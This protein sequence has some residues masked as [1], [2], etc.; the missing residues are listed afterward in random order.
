MSVRGRSHRLTINYRT[1]QEI[2]TWAVR[3]LANEKP[4]GLD[5]EADTLVGYRSTMHGRR[6]TIQSNP[7]REAEHE[8]LAAQIRTRIGD[9]VEPSSIGVAARHVWAAKSVREALDAAQI[10][11]STTNATKSNAVRVGTVHA[12]KGLEFRCVAVV[13]VEDGVVPAKGAVTTLAED[14]IAHDHDHQRERCLAFVAGTRA[15]D[16]LY[17]SYVGTPSPFLQDSGKTG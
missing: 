16:S 6:P 5:D 10:P 8:R 9:G 11:A 12:M 2:L 7:D 17:L 4:D 3:L 13:G 1:T 15:R 14:P